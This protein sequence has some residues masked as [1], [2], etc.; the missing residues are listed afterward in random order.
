MPSNWRIKE[1]FLEE[2]AHDLDLEEWVGS[3]HAEMNQQDRALDIEE[4][5]GINTQAE[6]WHVQE[7]QNYF[8]LAVAQDE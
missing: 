2:V 8:H 5:V 3:G 7:N 1:V 4:I 6:N